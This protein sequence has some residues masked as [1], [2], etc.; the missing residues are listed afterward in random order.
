VIALLLEAKPI[1]PLEP[2]P[3]PA[4]IVPGWRL[5]YPRFRL[6]SYPDR[7]STW[8]FGQLAQ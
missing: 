2:S 8:V 3:G 1:A 5:P 6:A 7:I 4:E